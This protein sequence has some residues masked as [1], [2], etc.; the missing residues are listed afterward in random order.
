MKNR[1]YYLLVLC[2]IMVV[3][4]ILYINGVFTGNIPDR[5]NLVINL[6]FLLIIGIIFCISIVSF[7]KVNNLAAILELATEDMRKEYT[8][9]RRVLWEE[10]SNKKKIFGDPDLDEPFRKY[11]KKMRTFKTKYGMTQIVDLED[12]INEELVDRV[13]MTYFNSTV[14]GTMTGLGILGTFLGLAIGLGSFNGTD[15]YT[16]SDNVGPLL[17]GMKVAFHTSVYGI[18]FSLIFTYVHRCVM[19]C[20]YEKLDEFLSG[21]KE[22]VE[23]PITT[24]DENM[25]AMLLYQANLAN[26]MKELT[27]L[28]KGQADNQI[29]GVGVIVDQFTDRMEKALCTD[30]TKLGTSLNKACQ[31]QKLYAENYS[32]MEQTTLALLKAT[33]DLQRTLETTMDRQEKLEKELKNQRERVEETCN[34]INEEISNQLFTLNRM[35]V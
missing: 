26:S 31:D 23:P 11:L 25:K 28:M 15:I 14:A 29:Q 12:Y 33:G 24:S 16:I 5:A 30:F 21:Y 10:Y 2:Y 34:R 17:G 6:V 4:I 35:K 19:S 1:M 3:G 13:G 8:E 32:K 7:V 27:M 20:A 9:K 18:F 22:Y